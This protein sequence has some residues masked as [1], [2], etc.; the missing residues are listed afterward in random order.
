MRYKYSVYVELITATLGGGKSHNG[1]PKIVIYEL[2]TEAYT[3]D[4]NATKYS[5]F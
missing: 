3:D 2:E 4:D 5:G 1:V